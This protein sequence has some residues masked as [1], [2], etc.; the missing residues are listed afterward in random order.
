MEVSDGAGHAK[1][2][3]ISCFAQFMVGNYYPASGMAQD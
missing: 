1:G 3:Y 2:E